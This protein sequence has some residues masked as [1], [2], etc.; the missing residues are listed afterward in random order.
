MN[1][2][3]KKVEN[4]MK[5]RGFRKSSQTWAGW[6]S[7]GKNTYNSDTLV[8]EFVDNSVPNDEYIREYSK[9]VQVQVVFDYN[10]DG[11][12]DWFYT[13]DNF[14]GIDEN[15]LQLIYDRGLRIPKYRKMTEH[16][17]GLIISSAT[18][19]ETAY[20]RSRTIHASE[21]N[22]PTYEINPHFESG[23]DWNPAD[24]QAWKNP[25]ECEPVKFYD[26]IEH[27]WVQKYLHGTQT[28]IKMI[29][30][31]FPKRGD[32]IE[33]L[34]D[35]LQFIYADLL[36]KNKFNLEVIC[37]VDGEV[38]NHRTIEPKYY[39]KSKSTGPYIDK[40]NLLGVDEWDDV[41]NVEHQGCE[42]TVYAGYRPH[43]DN[44][45]SYYEETKDEK[46]NPKIYKKSPFYH[47]VAGA[48]WHYK[49]NKKIVEIGQFK[50]SR[51]IQ[52]VGGF[53]EIRKGIPT[54]NTK[55]AIARNATIR[56]L[57]QKIDD[58][59]LKRGFKDR[60]ASH[61]PQEKESTMKTNIYKWG[62]E[63]QGVRDRLGWYDNFDKDEDVEHILHASII[64]LVN[65]DNNLNPTDGSV[66]ELKDS[67]VTF[68]Q[69]FQGLT[70]ALE[71]FQNT[72][73]KFRINLIAKEPKPS[74][75]VQSKINI[76]KKQGW[77]IQYVQYQELRTIYNKD[78]KVAA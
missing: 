60:S 52:S 13:T 31:P 33:T 30:R 5:Q 26:T 43:P 12:G 3:L 29:K 27:E 20:T 65:I 18:V 24:E 75:E 28:K 8:A 37:L 6:K 36:D 71:I 7:A 54:A 59:L 74:S 32:A 38:K 53:I 55:N 77:D 17:E 63:S 23:I 50:P 2:I 40:D 14:I 21:N 22:S 51:S 72:G 9:P 46:Y 10:S 67:V 69:V 68:G 66:N 49:K 19:G 56:E 61:L 42:V 48:G 62:I 4:K 73:K 16:G 44:V 34:C 78:T 64:D 25:I 70:Q 47:G 39:L 15:D 35:K 11:S 76:W 58:E 57:E 1:E 41:F 45:T